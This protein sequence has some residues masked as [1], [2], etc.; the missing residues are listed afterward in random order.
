VPFSGMPMN[1]HFY[2]VFTI[3]N[4]IPYRMLHHQ[5]TILLLSLP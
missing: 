5:L 4:G 3:K 1:W 2:K